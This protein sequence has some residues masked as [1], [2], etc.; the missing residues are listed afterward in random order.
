MNDNDYRSDCALTQELRDCLYDLATP[1]RPP[2]GAITTMGR[3]H[4]RRRLAGIAGGLGA[5]GVAAGAALA[6][7]LTGLLGA[8]PAQSASTI[9]TTAFTLTMNANGTATLKLNI[10]V[11]LEPGTLQTDLQHDGIPALVTTGSFCSSD[12]S[13][14]GFNQVTGGPK[15]PPGSPPVFTIN[16]AAMPAGTELSFGFFQLANVGGTGNPGEETAISLIDANSYTCA[17]I[18]PANGY[19][20]MVAHIPGGPK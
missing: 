16:R 5:T 19:G 18:P 8:A 6:L 20:V 13:P 15:S 2:L 1:E 9:R 10:N 17:S 7:G 4:Q 12:P 11:L 14:A 3:T